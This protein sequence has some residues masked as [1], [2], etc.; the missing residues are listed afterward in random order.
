ML[1]VTGKLPFG[2]KIGETTH[3]EFEI[4]EPLVEDM[5]E[6]EKTV[7]PTDLHAFNL[8]MLARVTVRVGSFEGPFS[9]G[10][11]RRLKRHDY[12]ALVQGMMQADN[13]GKPVSSGEAAT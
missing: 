6:A 8:E 3:Q 11:F 13:L 4:R 7:S 2:M 9:V 1:T 5:V 12:N 10:M